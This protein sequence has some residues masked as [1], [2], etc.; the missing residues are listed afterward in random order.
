MIGNKKNREQRTENRKQKIHFRRRGFT[1]VE[2]LVVLGI[3][4]ILGTLIVDVFILALQAQRQTSFR[5][6]T[7]SNLR[8]VMEVMTKQIRTSEIDYDYYDGVISP[9]E[10]TLALIDQSGK[11]IRYWLSGEGIKLSIDQGG[12]AEE[13]F[14]TNSEEIKA[15]RLYFYINPLTNPFSEEKC[16][17]NNG[18]T[19]C[20][21]ASDGCTINDAEDI[22]LS[23][24]CKC[25][26]IADSKCRTN[27]CDPNDKLCL[28][29]NQQPK[30]TIL[31]G[32]ESQAQKIEE[33][34]RIYLQTTVTSRV[35]KR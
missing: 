17:Q 11:K 14:L 34:K 32:F 20:L 29:F 30:V 2:I 23:G 25:D 13:S 4:A 6:K 5:Q 7:L 3:F 8:Y 24:F 10:T 27:Y 12:I 21:P 16:N 35:Y 31:L 9:Q 18:P 22:Y 19:G 1:L 26:P 15:V 33:Q 28:P